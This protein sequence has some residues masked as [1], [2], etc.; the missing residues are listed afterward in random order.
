LDKREYAHLSRAL[1]AARR[2]FS[3]RSRSSG[4]SFG[5]ILSSEPGPP[6]MHDK[7]IWLFGLNVNEL[8]EIC[9]KKKTLED[10]YELLS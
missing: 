6:R 10:L 5:S 7:F 8:E 2:S 3:R 1:F 9:N 4:V